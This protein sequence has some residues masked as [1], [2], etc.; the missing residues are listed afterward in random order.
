VTVAFAVIP[1]SHAKYTIVTLMVC[2]GGGG[3]GGTGVEV[4]RVGPGVRDAGVLVVGV[5]VGETRG[6]G[7]LRPTLRDRVVVGRAL[8]RALRLAL[9][10]LAGVLVARAV[11]VVVTAGRASARGVLFGSRAAAPIPM[12]RMAAAMAPT[13]QG[14]PDRPSNV[15]A[16][17]V[18]ATPALSGQSRL[19]RAARRARWRRPLSSHSAP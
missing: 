12:I 17:A 9:G 19:N 6:A 2:R 16:T 15:R 18:A 3:G 11:G 10:V 14:R 13:I 7:V 4:D 8:G 5:V 1:K